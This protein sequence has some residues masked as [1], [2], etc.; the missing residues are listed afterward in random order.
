MIKDTPLI[1]AVDQK[2]YHI[3]KKLLKIKSIEVNYNGLYH[4]LPL[5]CAIKNNSIYITKI[6]LNHP[7][8]IV[9][10]PP[11]ATFCSSLLSLSIECGFEDIFYLLIKHPNI[12]PNGKV[13]MSHHSLSPL[14]F[15][16]IC[17]YSE[18]VQTLLS[19]PTI[20]INIK[21]RLFG[22]IFW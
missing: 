11:P 12:D 20:D 15:A 22:L 8:I 17:N 18:I 21:D 16:T 5:Y 3:I 1:E 9:N 13:P 14:Y 7:D 6:L 2:N 10:Y 4:Y 19:N